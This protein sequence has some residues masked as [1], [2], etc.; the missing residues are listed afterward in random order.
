MRAVG[1]SD[2]VDDAARGA[3][4]QRVLL[5]GVGWHEGRCVTY[6]ACVDMWVLGGGLE[7]LEF[8]V[9]VVSGGG[10]GGCGL[11]EGSGGDGV[12]CWGEV[13]EGGGEDGV[14]RGMRWLWLEGGGA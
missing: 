5:W 14:G 12:V 6:G 11:R 8:A 1:Y 4:G 10:G 7:G 13:G 2:D 9:G 3:V